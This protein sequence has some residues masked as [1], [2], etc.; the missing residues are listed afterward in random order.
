MSCKGSRY[1]ETL[2]QWIWDMHRFDH[3]NLKTSCG[4]LLAIEDT[5]TLNPG[6]GP[7]FIHARLKIGSLV[8]YGDVEIHISE[9]EWVSHNHHRDK[10]YDTVVLHVVL[11]NGSSRVKTEDGFRPFCLNLSP[12]IKKPLYRLLIQKETDDQLPCSDNLSLLSENV[13]KKQL[14]TAQNEYLEFKVES[15]IAHYPS[16]KR[17]SQAWRFALISEIY[18]TLGMSG[19][20]EAMRKLSYRFSNRKGLPETQQEFVQYIIDQADMENPSIWTHTGMRPAARPSRRIK[21]AAALHFQII[22]TDFRDFIRDGAAIWD[23]ILDKVGTSYLPGRQ[24]QQ[25]LY[26]TAF[27]PGLHLLG[28][29]LFSDKLKQESKS[30]WK[31]SDLILP[32]KILEPFKKSG[33]PVD[34][35]RQNLGLVHQLKRYCRQRNCHRCELFKKSIHS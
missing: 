8:W 29:L 20:K 10:R 17:I 4:K 28:D 3:R 15:L 14:D 2:L 33:L 21:Q 11:Q 7:D 34:K 23:S 35:H 31:N 22:H 19:N 26:V 25:I 27:L 16:G 24:M 1:H 18:S 30:L 12:Y 5:G 32:D 13:F 6:K 9:P